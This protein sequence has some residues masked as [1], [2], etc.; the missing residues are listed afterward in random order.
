M[1]NKTKRTPEDYA[2]NYPSV[3]SDGLHGP[4]TVGNINHNVNGKGRTIINLCVKTPQSKERGATYS[5]PDDWSVSTRFQPGELVNI[6]VKGGFVDKVTEAKA[7]PGISASAINKQVE[8]SVKQMEEE[9][10]EESQEQVKEGV[11]SE[12]AGEDLPF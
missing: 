5:A 7:K 8:E 3:T 11:T 1:E 4:F 10:K 6:V 2:K 12:A 9:T